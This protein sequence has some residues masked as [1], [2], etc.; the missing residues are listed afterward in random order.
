MRPSY[1]AAATVLSPRKY[2]HVF[3]SISE[4]LLKNLRTI[5][6]YVVDRYF[7][8]AVSTLKVAPIGEW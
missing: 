1:S 5:A 2:A 4:R 6:P 7:I 8:G 3:F